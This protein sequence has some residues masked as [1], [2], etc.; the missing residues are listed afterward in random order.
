MRNFN[1]I[2][3]SCCEMKVL[4]SVLMTFFNKSDELWKQTTFQL[5]STL[6]W[7][8]EKFLKI[9]LRKAIKKIYPDILFRNFPLGILC[10]FLNEQRRDERSRDRVRGRRRASSQSEEREGI[11]NRHRFDMLPPDGSNHLAGSVCAS[12]RT[13][14]EVGCWKLVVGSWLLRFDLATLNY[15]W[16]SDIGND[17]SDFDFS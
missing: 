4:L 13:W 6:K 8:F 5:K 10:R 16:Y 11:R 1:R 14:L 2:L 3:H 12:R 15:R 9:R 17:N 7:S